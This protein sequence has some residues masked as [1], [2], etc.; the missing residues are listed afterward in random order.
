MSKEYVARLTS[1]GSAAVTFSYSERDD[2]CTLNPEPIFAAQL[3]RMYDQAV[4]YNQKDGEQI[5]VDISDRKKW[6]Q[7][8]KRAVITPFE[9]DRVDVFDETPAV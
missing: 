4:Y 8:M 5:V 6:V 1:R 2:K 7:A 9:C 3:E